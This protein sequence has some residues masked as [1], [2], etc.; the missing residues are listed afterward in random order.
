[1]TARV[2]RC[3]SAGDM[4]ALEVEAALGAAEGQPREGGLPSHPGRE[5]PHPV[6]VAPRVVSQSAL[7]GRDG[8]ELGGVGCDGGAHGV[9][10]DVQDC[11]ILT[12]DR[13]RPDTIAPWTRSPR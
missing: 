12:D 10:G 8:L 2:A 7:G 1:M 3:S 5:G 11:A 9:S 6:E 4:L 13:L